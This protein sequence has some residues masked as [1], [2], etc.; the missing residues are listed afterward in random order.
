MRVQKSMKPAIVVTGASSGIGLELARL[1]ARDGSFMLLIGL[2]HASLDE[3]AAE[4][5]AAGVQAEALA[6]DLSDPGSGERIE[7]ELTGRGLFCDVLVNCAGFGR[8]GLAAEISRAE[9]IKLLDV[10]VRALT[11]LSLRFL[12]G[13]LARGRGGILNVGSIAGYLSGPYMAVYFAS[14]AY[15]NSFSAALAN[16]A[17]GT[18]V[19][20]TCFAPGVTRTAFFERCGIGQ[21]RL[22]KLAPRANTP[23]TAAVGWRGFKTGKRVVIPGIGNRLIM[24]V[25]RFLPQRLLLW[26]VSATQRQL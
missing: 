8:Y 13:M 22:L 24:A 18:G 10:N 7:R 17:A 21:T 11:E 12:P 25:C 20:V 3:L 1:A 9:Q 14:K 23:E 2:S 16:E 15:V 26:F 6:I 4:F 19:T 5:A